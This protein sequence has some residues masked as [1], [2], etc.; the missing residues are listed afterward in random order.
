MAKNENDGKS[1]SLMLPQSMPVCYMNWILILLVR[2]R[3][4]LG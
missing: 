1:A 3:G 4:A 2:L